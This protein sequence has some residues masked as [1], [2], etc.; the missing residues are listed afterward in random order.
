MRRTLRDLADA[1]KDLLKIQEEFVRLEKRN[2]AVQATLKAA[3]IDPTDA[4][5]LH[6]Q[7]MA[8]MDFKK[9]LAR[10]TAPDGSVDVD[11]LLNGSKLLRF[12]KYGDSLT[13][14]F[15]SKDAAD[16]YM[17][18]LQKAQ[19]LGAHALKMQGVAKLLG[20][21]GLGAIGLGGVTKAVSKLSSQ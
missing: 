18:Q 14:F 6:Q 12:T 13:Q 2:D 11:K 5:A 19:E 16:A 17:T 4:D 15:G 20:K 8:G 3:G 7:R 9:L 1:R 21:I 10:A